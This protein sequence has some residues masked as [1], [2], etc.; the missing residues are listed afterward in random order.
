MPGQ[1]SLGSIT[2]NTEILE[3]PTEHGITRQDAKSSFLRFMNSNAQRKVVLPPWIL[4]AQGI[5]I[6]GAAAEQ[7]HGHSTGL[8]TSQFALP[9]KTIAEQ[10]TVGTIQRIIADI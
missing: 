2:P 4:A 7:I 6:V 10:L 3:S 9:H 5:G 1:N 8:D